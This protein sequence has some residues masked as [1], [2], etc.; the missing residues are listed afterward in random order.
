MPEETQPTPEEIQP[1]TPSPEAT[2]PAEGAGP[3]DTIPLSE[4]LGSAQEP[5]PT[6]APEPPSE[7]RFKRFL[8]RLLWTAAALLVVFAAGGAVVGWFFY[9]PARQEVSRLKQE[10]QQAQ[11]QSADLEV[12]KADLENQLKAAQN[13]IAELEA[14]VEQLTTERDT[15][16]TH[17]YLLTALAN[18]YAAQLALAD[19]D[20]T[21]ARLYLS[22]VKASLRL[23]EERLPE[24]KTVLAEMKQRADKALS[25]VSTSPLTAQG[26]LS[27][28]ANYLTQLETLLTT[29]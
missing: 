2:P 16:Q 12:Q 3:Q 22:N 27:A 7:S 29:P 5:S 10:V 21:S 9:R 4:A 23:L 6:A 25:L 14:Q 15:A 26:E 1:S 8:R 24:Q 13:R 20:T 17:E 18:T 19:K 11:Q 28:L